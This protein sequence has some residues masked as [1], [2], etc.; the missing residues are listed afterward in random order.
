MGEPIRPRAP[1]TMM[2]LAA[3]AC[4]F[5]APAAA[6]RGPAERPAETRTTELHAGLP[7]PAFN[8][9]QAALLTRT[10]AILAGMKDAAHR[11]GSPAPSSSA[12][13]DYCRFLDRTWRALDA[14]QFA[15]VRRWAGRE[16]AAVPRSPVVYYPFSGPDFLYASLL[17]P[18][19]E[20]FI[21][22][23]LEPVGDFPVDPAA[24]DDDLDRMVAVTTPQLR[25]ILGLTFFRTNDLEAGG[26]TAGLL[27]A[28]L[29]RTGH[30]ILDAKHVYIGR[31]GRLHVVPP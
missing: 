21:L 11:A 5:A 13:L 27:F 9:A 20:V 8:A 24:L 2:A 6:P 10:G 3:A 14:G 15:R 19:A 29:V 16:L 28:F 25:D 4:L 23:G 7:I 31:E 17:F 30:E 1:W 26:P 22:T 18:Q 12:W